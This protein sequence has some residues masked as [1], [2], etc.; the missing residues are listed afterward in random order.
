MI[1]GASGWYHGLWDGDAW[2]S[3]ADGW[4]DGIATARGNANL[5]LVI[6]IGEHG[7]LFINSSYVSDLDLSGWTDEG[8]VSA[9][10]SFY[11][12]HGVAGVST[13]FERFAVW[14]IAELP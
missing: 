10:A 7:Y 8:V 4:E 1:D 9:I 11:F 12:G 13:Q 2:E 14:S 6:M 3:L 5:L